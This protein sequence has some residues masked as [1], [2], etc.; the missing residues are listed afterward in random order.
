MSEITQLREHLDKRASAIEAKVDTH[1]AKMEEK[2]DSIHEALYEPDDG[3]F[4]RA[5]KAV[6]TSND[7]LQAAYK[8]RVD[9]D[10]H[11]RK[12]GELEHAT[13]DFTE[14]M[15]ERKDDRKWRNRL[16]IGAIVA[17]CGSTAT[18]I[19]LAVKASSYSDKGQP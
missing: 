14:Y 13:V 18:S 9:V 3:V 6:H 17:V 7:A 4:A 5:K 19:A 1:Y 10:E 12:I 15:K 8:L 2:I 11:N 16:I